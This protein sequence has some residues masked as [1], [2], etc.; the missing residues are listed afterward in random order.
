[1]D[2]EVKKEKRDAL[3]VN[4]DATGLHTQIPRWGKYGAASERKMKRDGREAQP[5]LHNGTQ[6]LLEATGRTTASHVP[7]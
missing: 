2:G 4:E 7:T 5:A 1:M 6:H 3:R